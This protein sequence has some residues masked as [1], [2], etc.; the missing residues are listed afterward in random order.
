M[1][2]H[3]VASPTYLRAQISGKRLL[4]YVKSNDPRKN[5]YPKQS[6]L[7]HQALLDSKWDDQE[8]TNEAM[9]VIGPLFVYLNALNISTDIESWDGFE[10]NLKKKILDPRLP[11]PH[12]D[13]AMNFTHG[14]I[15][16]YD[17]MSPHQV[18]F[19]KDIKSSIIPDLSRWS[20]ITYL[21]WAEV[22]KFHGTEVSNLNYVIQHHVTNQITLDVIKEVLKKRGEWLA[23]SG[24][25]VSMGDSNGHGAAL[26]GTPNGKG[27]VWLLAQHKEAFKSLTII[28]VEIFSCK[29]ANNEYETKLEHLSD[30]SSWFNLC[31]R[32]GQE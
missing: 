18:A 25:V 24:C 23:P 5:D 15:V 22:C 17:S 13:L 4:A 20:D 10:I 12:Y 3:S 6:L 1:S 2:Q 26:L 19:L 7:N 21:K 29:P 9:N 14:V 27:V 11:I 28:S 8:E 31:F 16:A 32:M 30:K